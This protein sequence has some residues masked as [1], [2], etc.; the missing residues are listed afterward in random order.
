[1]FLILYIEF[2]GTKGVQ[3]IKWA[4][5]PNLKKSNKFLKEWKY[6]DDHPTKTKA[7]EVDEKGPKK[8]H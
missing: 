2:H 7:D 6:P 5:P 3:R 1:M 4:L 8:I